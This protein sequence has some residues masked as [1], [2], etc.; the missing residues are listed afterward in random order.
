[1]TRLLGSDPVLAVHDLD[2][3]ADWYRRVLGCEVH[4]VAPGQWTFC[5]NGDVTFRI[6]VCPESLPAS[7]L[8]D[9]SYVAYLRV[10]DVDAAHDLAVA[11][12]ADIIHPPVDEPWGMREMALRSPEGHRFMLAQP[13]G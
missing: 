6:G 7:E 12:G 11:E 13:T 2:A 4:E 9:H 3:S 8:G 10:D 5:R 1:M